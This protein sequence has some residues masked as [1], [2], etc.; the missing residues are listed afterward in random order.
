MEALNIYQKISK[1]R[2]LAEVIQKN[3]SGYGYKYTSVDEILA[4]VTAG[5]QQ[6]NLLLLPRIVP[7]TCV[8]TPYTYTTVQN[9]KAGDKIEKIN[10]EIIV[11]HDLTFTWVN[12]DNPKEFIEIPWTSV[13]SQSD[14]SQALGSG[15]TYSL[16]QFLTQFFQIAA[17]DD[18]DPDAW[19]A[20]QKQA[21]MEEDRIVKDSIIAKI[22]EFIDSIIGANPD[23]KNEIADVIK[24][25]IKING[26]A[27]ANYLAIEDSET[28]ANLLEILNKHFANN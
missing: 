14:P 7:G 4:K 9:T 1:V 16:R 24:K 22:T 15:L 26:K 13:G 2:K 23:K 27:S 10:N 3:K 18:T 6:H 12:A 19:R 21:Q 20:K 11:Q 5:M 8:V 25:T 28:A 17:L